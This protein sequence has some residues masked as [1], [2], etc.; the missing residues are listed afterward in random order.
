MS[1][2]LDFANAPAEPHMQLVR[3]AIAHHRFVWI[4]PF[5]NGNGRVARLFSYAMIRTGGFAPDVEYQTVNPTTVFGADR[6]QYYDRLSAA[7]S[8]RTTPSSNGL[9]S[10][11]T[12]CFV[13]SKR[14]TCSPRATL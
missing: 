6:Q 4:H 11:S 3:M 8:S 5:A 1:D 7:D 9:T 12:G 2:L 14:C 10:Y 13:T